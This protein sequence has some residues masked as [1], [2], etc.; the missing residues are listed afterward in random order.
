MLTPQSPRPFSWRRV[1]LATAGRRKVTT[2]M[3]PDST[4]SPPCFPGANFHWRT[5]PTVGEVSEARSRT[6]WIELARPSLSTISLRTTLPSPTLCAGYSGFLIFVHPRREFGLIGLREL[7]DDSNSSF[8]IV[9]VLACGQERPRLY[10]AQHF[11]EKW[12][13]ALDDPDVRDLSPRV[14]LGVEENLS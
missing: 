14:N 10:R 9:A 6:T 11:L 7:E 3:T 8:H 2:T 5:A 13:L 12:W 1:R 4:A